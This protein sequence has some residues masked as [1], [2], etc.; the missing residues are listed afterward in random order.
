MKHINKSSKLYEYISQIP[1]YII[2]ISLLFLVT[3]FV[4]TVIGINVRPDQNHFNIV[5]YNPVKYSETRMLNMWG[6]W[7]SEWYLNIARSGYTNTQHGK[8]NNLSFAFFPV[9]PTLINIVSK[10]T[11]F[12]L[13]TSAVFISNLFFICSCLILYKLATLDANKKR[14]IPNY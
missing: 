7:D 13:F 4:L 2:Y 1:E 3:R 6:R 12:R 9:F 8:E 11:R 10:I 5:P 14:V